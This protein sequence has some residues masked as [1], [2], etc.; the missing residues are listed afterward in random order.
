VSGRPAVALLLLAA[1]ARPALHPASLVVGGRERTYTWAGP[2]GGRRPLVIALHGRG[3]QG[4]SEAKLSH[5]DEIARREGFLVVFPDG[6]DRSWADGRGATPAARNG[7]DDVGFVRA[8]IDRLVADGRV[9]PARVYVTGMSNGAI[10]TWTLACAMADRLAAIAP[11]SGAMPAALAESCTPARPL[12]VLYFAG[13]DDPILPYGGGDTPAGGAVLSAEDSVGRWAAHDG[14]DL[15][16]SWTE[17]PDTDPGDGT[18]A[19]ARRLT[20]CRDGVEVEL[21]TIDHGGHTWPGGLAYAPERRIGKTSR[22]L[23]ASEE[24]WRFF[25]RFHR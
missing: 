16:A 3:G 2:D 17:L 23:D 1:C 21:V 20:G 25:V 11:V 9:D 14:C 5:L 10:M 15:T 8:L 22:D 18:R 4:Q 24:M 12:A 19:R 6:I 7:V 13:T